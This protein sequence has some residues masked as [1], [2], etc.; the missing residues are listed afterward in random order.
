MGT[1]HLAC[2][3]ALLLSAC[4]SPRV[5]QSNQSLTVTLTAD[6]Q[7]KSLSVPAGNKV[8]QVLQS[9]GI[10]L[11][12]LD[13]VN[14]QVYT[15]VTEGLAIKVIRG[16][17]VFETKRSIL[18]FD[19]Q[20]VRNEDM[21]TGQ[22][23]LLQPGTN[24][25]QEI[26]YRYYYEDDKLVSTSISRATVL[27]PALPEI[28][29]VGV[30][31][32]FAPLPIPGKLI[33]ISG[34]SAWLM[35]SSTS[36]RVPLVTSADLD[37]RILKLSSDGNWLLYTR[38]SSKTQDVEINTLWALNISDPKATPIDL[39]TS[40]IIHFADWDPTSGTNLRVL[41]S[42]VEPRS[43]APGW[44]AN[45]DL[46]R[47]VLGT[48]GNLGVR[49]KIIDANTGGLYG[50]WGTDYF[51]APAGNLLA[52]SR[53]DGVGIVSFANKTLLPQLSFAP[54]QTHSN[55]ALIPGLVWGADGR[56]LYVV[57]HAPPPELVNPEESP[58]FDLMAISL[59]SS[60][61]VRLVEQSGMF[62]YPSASSPR[63]IGKER[64]YELAY[65]QAISKS[66]SDTSGY[67][68]VVMDRDGSNH[69]TLFPDAG[70]PG[71]EPQTPIWAPAPISYVEGDFLAVIYQGNL[72][73]VDAATGKSHQITSDGLMQKIEW[74]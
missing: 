41:Y 24:G 69:R 37:G 50:W 35:Q 66:Q 74:K 8:S 14:P 59:E 42:T 39:K 29:M 55:W 4:L 54:L 38:K 56:T 25:T 61:T 18:P 49:E 53:P 60:I 58:N 31:A 34:G 67:R 32:P 19:R 11:G 63:Q 5:S 43:A 13:K 23:R 73:L 48:N 64:S 3:L 68:L 7:T 9:A 36:N 28:V 51:W 46:Y 70:S 2:W 40:N 57:S 52:Y 10:S 27:E 47:M 22:T 16:R 1:F 44:Q 21:P 12:S 71:L 45:N 6:G 72:W 33:Y 26:V 15:L 62:A 30:Q 17:E 65:L 20:T